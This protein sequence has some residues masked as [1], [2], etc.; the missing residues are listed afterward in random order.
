MTDSRP[1][2]L[3]PPAHHAP[4]LL[5]RLEAAVRVLFFP[6]FVLFV[7]WV[8]LGNSIEID[9]W[10]HLA[11]G[12]WMVEN[13]QL[14]TTDPFSYTRPGAI[15]SH[16]GAWYEI[17]LYQMYTWL[18]YIGVDLT[19]GVVLAAPFC[20]LWAYL[21]TPHLRRFAL[22]LSGLVLSAVYW[23]AR[24]NIFTL[25]FTLLTLILLDQHQRGSRWALWLLPVV[26]VA[27]VNTHGGWPVGF[28]LTGAFALDEIR[29]PR[30]LNRA[31]LRDQNYRRL[32]QFAL[33]LALMAAAT[34]INPYGWTMHREMF[35]TTTRVAED[36]MIQEWQSPN[37]HRPYGQVFLAVI[38]ISAVIVVRRRG[39][40]QVG[41]LAALA[42]VLT[43]GLVS[44][45]HIAISAVVLPLFWAD[46]LGWR[47]PAGE[48]LAV[49]S[50]APAV[51]GV[52]LAFFCFSILMF[53]GRLDTVLHTPRDLSAWPTGAVEYLRTARPEGHIFNNYQMG[54]YL[55]W[56]LP[57]YPVFL[58]SRSDIYGD[59]IIIQSDRVERALPGWEAILK[60]W[61]IR[62]ALTTADSALSSALAQK[63]EWELCQQDAASV[64]WIQTGGQGCP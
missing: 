21:K 22:V 62:I 25:L 48:K 37:F 11:H 14:L 3:Q 13:G 2:K 26:M 12:R 58:D 45:R 29:W 55:I 63:P 35:L 28:L 18:G 31:A 17:L 39:P 19:A 30:R 64:L 40:G 32:G 6:G 51:T 59:E 7:L 46:L 52:A 16:P 36:T 20:V 44:A 10:W 56:A 49:K 50:P 34:F 61:D 38:L 33:V 23:S 24:P 54:G 43:M 42:G 9:S 53:G 47:V 27:W 1:D 41:R 4:A 60:Q 8:L 15:W 5:P 57:E